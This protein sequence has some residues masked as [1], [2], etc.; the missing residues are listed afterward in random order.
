MPDI[1]EG[2]RYNTETRDGVR[3]TEAPFNNS[4]VLAAY[5]VGCDDCGCAVAVQ[6]QYT[7]HAGDG[8]PQPVDCACRCHEAYNRF[9]VPQPC[10]KAAVA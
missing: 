4:S 2:W 1:L 5:T 3:W 6:G 10:K 7:R 8:D 9:A